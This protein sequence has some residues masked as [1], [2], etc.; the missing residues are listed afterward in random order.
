MS[1]EIAAAVHYDIELIKAL[2][3]LVWPLF[4]AVL[5]WKLFPAIKSIVSSRAFS[6]KIGGMEVNVQDVTEQINARI[7]D[8]QRQVLALRGNDGANNPQA[9][10]DVAPAE[11]DQPEGAG[12]KAIIW[13][14]DKPSGNAFEIAQLKNMGVEV[15]ICLSTAEALDAIHRRPDVKAIISDM[16][17]IEDGFYRGKAGI[18]LLAALRQSGINTP[19]MIYSTAKYA[20]RRNDEAIATGGA[21]AISSQV[22]LLEWLRKQLAAFPA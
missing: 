13:A 20:G 5:V 9:S 11:T 21:G 18:E 10:T 16:G 19:Y 22:E 17:R 1:K 12:S 7:E 3:P 8:L 15:I 14:D 6:V 2:A 4:L